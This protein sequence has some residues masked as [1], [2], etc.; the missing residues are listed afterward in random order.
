M[1][2]IALSVLFSLFAVIA[3]HG[4]SRREWLQF[5]DKAFDDKNYKLALSCYQ[6]VI[7]LTPG[8]DRDLVTPYECRP[9]VNPKKSV[10][11]AAIKAAAQDSVLKNPNLVQ[12]ND[13]RT[14]WVTHRV[15]ECYRL[16]HDYDNAELWYRQAIFLPDNRFPDT[17]FYYAEALMNMGKYEEAIKQFDQYSEPLDAS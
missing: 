17:R 7:T 4:Q 3:V 1:R 13:E 5:G 11:T 14:R 16:L 6:H 15:A 12:G 10:D 8:N 9:Y 2:R